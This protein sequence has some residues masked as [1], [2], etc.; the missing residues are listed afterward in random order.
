MSFF[1][2]LVILKVLSRHSYRHIKG[3]CLVISILNVEVTCFLLLGWKGNILSI[4]L[5]ICQCINIGLCKMYSSEAL[6]L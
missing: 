5:I 4:Q 1:S 3:K 6:W 2:F